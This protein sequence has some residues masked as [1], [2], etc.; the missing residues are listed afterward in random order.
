MEDE[1]DDDDLLG[2]DSLLK[3]IKKRMAEWILK[4]GTVATRKGG[5][6]IKTLKDETGDLSVGVRKDLEGTSTRS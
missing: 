2:E 5:K 3:R 4:A 1:E 6:I